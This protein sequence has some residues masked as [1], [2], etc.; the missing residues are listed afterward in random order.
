MKPDPRQASMVANFDYLY[1][2][3]ELRNYFDLAR[4]ETYASLAAQTNAKHRRD[5]RPW[6]WGYLSKW[7]RARDTVSA[8]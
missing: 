1:S 5:H 8:R 6:P 4:A 7:A 3:E 2:S